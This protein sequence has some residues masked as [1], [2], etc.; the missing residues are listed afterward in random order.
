MPTDTFYRLP[1]EKRN[2]LV[3]AIYD[4]LARVP[5]TEMSIN[6][7]VHGAGISRGSFYQYFADRDDLIRFLLERV[8]GCISDY[9]T[10]AAP[11]CGG[12]PFELLRRILKGVRQLSNDP[13]NRAFC[14]NLLTHLRANGDVSHCRSDTFAP[15]RIA[16]WFD[17]HF[18][19]SMLNVEAPE[20]FLLMVE[21][22]Q[23]V[24]RSTIAQ[25]FTPGADADAIERMFSRKLTILQRGMMKKE[26]ER[27][28]C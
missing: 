4:E 12:D 19:R 17:A 10:T 13:A 24:L 3:V 14:T 20:D 26:G 11:A 6:R 1:E 18:D 8:D 5:V 21:L 27:H 16:E 15:E 9:S 22:L 2:R 28:A 25:M 7:I 23:T